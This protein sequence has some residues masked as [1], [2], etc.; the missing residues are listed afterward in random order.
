MTEILYKVMYMLCTVKK[1]NP[2]NQNPS[3]IFLKI[4]ELIPRLKGKGI[5]VRKNILKNNKVGRV[6]LIDI[7]AV[8][9]S[10]E[11]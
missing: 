3:K 10:T 6:T 4:N 2:S 1:Q 5:R 8:Y 7:K 11:I 9:K